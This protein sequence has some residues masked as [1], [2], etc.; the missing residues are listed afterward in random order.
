MK[1]V[2]Q[3]MKIKKTKKDRMNAEMR[4]DLNL[5]ILLLCV[6]AV[7]N[8]SHNDRGNNVI[9]TKGRSKNKRLET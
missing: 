4:E 6:F 2:I 9:Y 8:T 1:L 3:G 7:N 5:L